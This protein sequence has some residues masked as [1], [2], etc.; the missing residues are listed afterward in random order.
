MELQ[1]DW[2]PGT[3]TPL[4]TDKNLNSQLGWFPF[5]S[6]PGGAGSPT[7]ALGGG[8]GY[9]CTTGAAEPACADFLK[10]LDTPAVQAKVV[11]A[12]VGLPA[13]P[14]AAS[15]LTLPAMQS[16]QQYNQ[17]APFIQVYFDI[18]MPTN[19]G[20]TLDT[21]IANF[22]AGQAT[23]QSIISTVNQAAKTQ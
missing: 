8:D 16:V 6:V 11:A 19:V 20:Q 13:N 9:S 12:N 7:T 23:P 15:A 21:A 22:F 14:A 10:Y 18:A 2:D 5:P 4:T 3:M 1:G 17:A